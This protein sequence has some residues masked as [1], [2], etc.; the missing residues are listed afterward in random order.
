MFP[1]DLVISMLKSAYNVHTLPNGAL[2]FHERHSHGLVFYING[3]CHY[4]YQ[5]VSC[6]AQAGNLLFLPKGVPYSIA[7]QGE[8]DCLCINFECEQLMGCPFFCLHP[9]NPDTVRALFDGFIT[10]W[11]RHASGHVYQCMAILYSVFSELQRSE[12]ESELSHPNIHQIKNAYD[13]IHKHYNDPGLRVSSLATLCFMS[14]RSFRVKFKQAFGLPPVK[15]I[16]DLRMTYAHDL[17]SSRMIPV[18]EV[19][20]RCGYTDIYYFSRV[21]S[22]YYG[23]APSRFFE[24]PFRR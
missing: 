11:N 24:D 17:L 10:T 22:Q 14:E 12:N 3:V 16:T 1:N 20:V 7:P 19:A 13:Y 21:F 15:Y 5:S 8:S 2:S 18:S 23:I 4:S 9:T 6:A